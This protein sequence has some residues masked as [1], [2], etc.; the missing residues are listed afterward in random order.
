MTGDEHSFG[1]PSG[2]A[3]RQLLGA[4]DTRLGEMPE[5]QLQSLLT[6][7]QQSLVAPQSREATL[8]NPHCARDASLPPEPRWQDRVIIEQI[9]PHARVLD[10]GCGEGWLLSQLKRT[11]GIDGQGV[12]LSA[13]EVFRSVQRGVNVLQCDLDEGLKGFADQSFDYVVLEET[14]Q[15]LHHPLRI[16]TEILRVGRR[17]IVTFPNFGYWRVRL[18]LAVRG[19]MPVTERLPHRWYDTP[20]IHLLCLSDF[21]DWARQQ[22]IRLVDAKVLA[23][24]QVRPMN[25]DDGLYAQEVLIVFEKNS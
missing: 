9:P 21:L 7:L 6:E 19:R 25:G 17:G 11:K 8:V 1:I 12:E 24:G 10:L 3:L 18:D 14:L 15:T 20:N 13:E 23:D 5:P 2:S 4:M 22:Q 16:L